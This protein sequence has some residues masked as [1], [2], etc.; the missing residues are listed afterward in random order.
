MC[1]EL[2]IEPVRD[3]RTTHRRCGATACV[4][5]CS[6]WRTRSPGATSRRSSLAPPACCATTDALLDELGGRGR[7]DRCARRRRGAAGDRPPG[8]AALAHRRRLPARRGQRRAGARRG[9]RRG[10]GVRAVGRSPRRTQ[11]TAVPDRRLAASSIGS[12]NAARNPPPAPEGRADAA[13][14]SGQVGARHHPSPLHVDPQGQAGDLR[15]SWRV[16]RQPPPRA[17]PGGDHLDPR[18]RVQ[19]RDLDHPGAPQPAQLRGAQPPV[20]AP[21]VQGRRPGRRG[22]EPS[23]ARSTT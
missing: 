9:A 17:P 7:R 5:S 19:L 14:A 20:P 18:E 10:G 6:R 8:A 11:P 12:R 2:G 16:R 4:T 13:Q 15:A 1:A 21:A 23:T 3:R 22:C